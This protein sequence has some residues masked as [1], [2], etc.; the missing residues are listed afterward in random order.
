MQCSIVHARRQVTYLV[1]S[2]VFYPDL[3]KLGQGIRGLFLC[4]ISS[5]GHRTLS[6]MDVD[7]NTVVAFN[8]L[9][10]AL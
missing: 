2:H 8:R 9:S 1:K 7:V 6:G 4:G 3:I 10:F 5:R